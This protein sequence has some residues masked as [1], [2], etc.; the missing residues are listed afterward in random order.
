MSVFM[1]NCAVRFC[2]LMGYFFPLKVAC[3]VCI[4]K[5]C[6]P[7][8]GAESLNSKAA[9][10]PVNHRCDS[11]GSLHPWCF[12]PPAQLWMAA[13]LQICTCHTCR[14]CFTLIFPFFQATSPPCT[15]ILPSSCASFSLSAGVCLDGE[16]VGKY[17]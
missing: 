8:F 5:R 11:L 10:L 9:T 16:I 2:Y 13:P 14:C 6:G 7:W 1:L 17:I 15:P 4:A 3:F 12:P